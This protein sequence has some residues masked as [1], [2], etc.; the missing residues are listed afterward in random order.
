VARVRLIHWNDAE[1]SERQQ[2][3]A[4]LGHRAEFAMPKGPGVMPVVRQDPPEVYVI[5]LSRLPSHGREAALALRTHKATRHVPLVF[6]DGEPEKVARIRALLPDAVYTTWGRVK[7]AI[8]RALSRHPANPIVPKD[9]FSDRP[10]A[11]KLGIKPGHTVCLL[12]SPRGFAATLDPLP[13]K[14]RFTARI[15]DACDLFIAFAHSA[16]DLAA[17][18]ALVGR[19]LE[20][21]PLWLLWPKKA[22]GVR[23]DLDGN[24]VRETGLAAGLVDYKVCSVD[25][26]W[27]GLAFK[28]R[29]R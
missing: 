25:A 27:S 15:A 17:Q 19:V 5:D 10:T 21:Q 1:G 8:P 24:V 22:S 20:D 11:A 26:T 12:G 14:V 28:R 7:T 18:I 3:L 23:S 13:A 16:R 4:A 9:P 2:Q 6:V 29:R